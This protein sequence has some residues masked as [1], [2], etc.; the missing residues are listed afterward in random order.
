MTKQKKILSI[1]VTFNAEA[2]LETCIGSLVESGLHTDIIVIDNASSDS[3]TNLIEKNYPQ[4]QLSKQR[5]NLG[6][7]KANNIGFQ[8][9][10]KNDYD[11]VFLLNQDA[12]ILPD[13]L[14]ILTNC[15]SNHPEYG[16]ISPLQYFSESKLDRFFESYLKKYLSEKEVNELLS[17][18]FSTQKEIYPIP[19]VNAAI[20][21]VSKACLQK[22][23]GFD[24]DFEHYGEDDEFMQRVLFY[25]FKIGVCPKAIGFHLRA[26]STS[27]H[28]QLHGDALR[29]FVNR[30]AL[31]LLKDLK[32]PF[33]KAAGMSIFYTLKY[34]LKSL[35]KSHIKDTLILVRLL[36]HFSG[37]LFYYRK[38]KS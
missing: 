35:L 4:V 3:T 37:R 12:Y 27:P 7:G 5:E 23:R 22:V 15:H 21:L 31:I 38:I 10:L 8:F 34:I 16:V 26:Q 13:T 28:Q 25:N 14:T 2:W 30:H 6:F 18:D 29:K 9:A 17:D 11:Y 1:I 33:W 36:F 24:A 20:W 19:Y 32:Q